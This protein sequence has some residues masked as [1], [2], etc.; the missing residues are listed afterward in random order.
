MFDR[1]PADVTRLHS[2]QLTLSPRNHRH[3]Q[4]DVGNVRILSRL[5]HFLSPL[6]PVSLPAWLPAGETQARGVFVKVE[7]APC[8]IND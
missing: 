5:L 2:K 8:L 6:M 1:V 7:L 4:N 3:S